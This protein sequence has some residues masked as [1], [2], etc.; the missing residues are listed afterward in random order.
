MTITEIDFSDILKYKK[1]VEKCGLVF[2]KSTQYFG[3]FDNSEMVGFMGI[4]LYKNKI[5]HKNIYIFP[6][7]RGKGYFKFC[8]DWCI[9]YAEKLNI[10]VIE[11]TC[12]KMSIKEYLKR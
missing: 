1:E 7:F 8:L 12:T 2:C 4:I 10:F 11:A 9:Q 5:V 3:I 6:M